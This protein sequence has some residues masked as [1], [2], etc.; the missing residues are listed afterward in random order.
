MDITQI[1]CVSY[2]ILAQCFFHADSIHPKYADLLK[3]PHFK[4]ESRLSM[5]KKRLEDANPDII[6]LQEVE[7]ETVDSDFASL[8]ETYDRFNHIKNKKRTSP[9]GNVTLWRKSI[10]TM[11]KSSHNSS[12]IYAEFKLNNSDIHFWTLNLHL[13]AGI[14]KIKPKTER[15]AQMT[16]CLKMVNTDL[17]GY[18]SGDFN[19][20][21]V[22]FIT[23]ENEHLSLLPM[24]KEKKFNVTSPGDTCM[25]YDSTDDKFNYW[26][27]DHVAYKDLKIDVKMCN[28]PD[29]IQ[30]FPSDTEPSDHLMIEFVLIIN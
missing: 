15:Y 22:S 17:P 29:N 9:I 25:V 8:F 3:T 1:K 7:L 23:K 12:S 21:F 24:L 27:F 13:R 20:D 14:S 10:L 19:D 5:I 16:S 28:D 4:W 2:N 30:I 18:I 6:F 11:A 26:R